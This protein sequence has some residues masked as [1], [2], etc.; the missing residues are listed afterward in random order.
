MPQ[1]ARVPRWTAAEQPI[2]FSDLCSGAHRRIIDMP[3]WL[4]AHGPRAL[5]LLLAPWAG[6]ALAATVTVRAG[7]TLEAIAQRQGV[8]LE[9]LRQ[10]NPQ[11]QPERLAVGT[12]LQL[13][14]PGP[15][16]VVQAGDTLEAIAQRQG[17]SLAAL[18][19]L[20]PGVQPERLAVGSVLKLP[21]G[22]SGSA[23]KFN[24]SPPVAP[25][26]AILPS[27]DGVTKEASAALLMS[28]AERRDRAQQLLVD[29]AGWR[30]YGGTAVDWKGWRLH[31][32]GV[33]ITLVK[34]SSKEL[35]T[36]RALA[37]AVAVQCDTLRQTW[38]ID[39]QWEP[40]KTPGGGTVP[41][42]IVLDLCSNTTDA[43]AVPVL[44]LEQGETQGLPLR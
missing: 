8:S 35:G 16:A 38:R 25:A 1:R 5:A 17:V 10:L 30:W 40:W 6:A 21:S 22:G 20:N 33:R 32:G 36:I 14:P 11:V 12:V 41:A 13:P 28:A 7:D 15:I 18:L 29:P 2:A 19:A 23:A 27:P 42:R 9:S 34:P 43:P 39:G 44:P 26:A 4:R 37:T 24:G 31:P 3:R